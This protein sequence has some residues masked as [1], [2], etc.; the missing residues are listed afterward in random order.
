VDRVHAGGFVRQSVVL[1]IRRRRR[2]R[3]RRRHR[4]RRRRRRVHESGCRRRCRCRC[5]C[6]RCRRSA[7]LFF[8]F[9]EVG[10]LLFHELLAAPHLWM[11]SNSSI[12]G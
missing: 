9:D 6:R 2:R 7:V 11:K 10:D 12:S 4:R 5:S 3:C 8:L 1:Q